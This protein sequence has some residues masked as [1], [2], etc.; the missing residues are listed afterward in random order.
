M[1]NHPPMF[2]MKKNNYFEDQEN[3]DK[4]KELMVQIYLNLWK[5]LLL[6]KKDSKN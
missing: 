1:K 2:L 6:N 3:L 5:K 4:L